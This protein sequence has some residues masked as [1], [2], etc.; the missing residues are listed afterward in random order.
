MYCEH[1]GAWLNPEI[2]W[3]FM[4]VVLPKRGEHLKIVERLVL[5]KN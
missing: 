1:D 4:V 2:A 5:F 3:T